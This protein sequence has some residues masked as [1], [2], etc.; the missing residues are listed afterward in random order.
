[1]PFGVVLLLFIA[2]L[3]FFGLLHNVLDRMKLTDTEAL[4][5]IGLMVVGSFI[6]I[7]ISRG[8]VEISVNVGG[9]L[10]PVALAIYI[11]R[12]AKSPGEWQ[13]ALISA[14]GTGLLLFILVKNF[15]FEEGHTLV[16]PQYI[17]AVAAAFIAYILGRSRRSAFIGGIMGVLF[18][19]LAYLIEAL[20]KRVPVE[21]HL[22]G[23]GLFDV[24]LLAGVLAVILAE[25]VGETLE[26]I[27]GGPKEEEREDTN[28][29]GE[30]NA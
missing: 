18:L 24:M 19:D 14:V 5:F 25:V 10:I 9:G 21:L 3:I 11:L 22:G 28:D 29:G 17:F 20:V 15:D 16:D 13:R 8:T 7:P 12:K 26:S 23:A 6:N 30:G 1:M 4:I 27:Q 2:A